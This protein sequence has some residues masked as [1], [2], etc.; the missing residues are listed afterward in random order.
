M[1]SC[2]KRAVPGSLGASIGATLLRCFRYS[3]LLTSLS[4]I[5][6]LIFGF[7]LAFVVTTMIVAVCIWLGERI[8]RNRPKKDL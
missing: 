6:D 1:W 2:I 8:F 3:I 7:A 4:G 5:V